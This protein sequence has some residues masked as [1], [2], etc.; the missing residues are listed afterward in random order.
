MLTHAPK[1]SEKRPTM[2]KP[3]RQALA[4]HGRSAPHRVTGKLRTAIERMIWQ[5]DK[6]ADAAVAAGMTDHGLRSA[7]RKS[8][9]KAAY[10]AELDLLRTSER[11]RNVHALVD[12]RDASDNAMARVAAAK[13]LERSA[14]QQPPFAGSGVR[15]GLLIVVVDPQGRALPTQPVQPA[16]RV[17]EL[18]ANSED[19]AAE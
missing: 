13:E 4:V 7:L 5:G 3:T 2:N 17:I 6:R 14:E 19:D 9:V 12:V 11:A 16:P 10:L 15:P 18:T 1:H 8:H